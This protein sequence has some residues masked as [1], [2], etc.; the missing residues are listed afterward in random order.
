VTQLQPWAWYACNIQNNTTFHKEYI[1]IEAQTL[2]G[3]RLAA[4][5]RCMAVDKHNTMLSQPCSAA[6]LCLQLAWLAI[7]K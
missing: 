5:T 7:A 2:Q 4:A 3:W 1:S 6:A